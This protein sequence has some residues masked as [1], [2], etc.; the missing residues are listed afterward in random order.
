MYRSIMV[1]VDLEHAQALHK[2]LGTAAGLAR[3]FGATVTYV[4]VSSSAPGAVA[5]NPEEF[6]GRLAAFASDE[7][8]RFGIET[9]S[10]ACISHDPTADLDRTLLKAAEEL[11]ADLIVMASH[12]PG[13]A[14]HIFASHAGYVASHAET[15]VFVVR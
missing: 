14:E 9:S 7:G 13:V 8:R 3:Q 1:P 2:A 5:H 6:A 10:L 4:A 11:L 12:V 15:S